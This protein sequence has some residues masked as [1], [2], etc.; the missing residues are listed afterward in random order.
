MIDVDAPDTWPSDVLAWAREASDGLSLPYA[1]EDSRLVLRDHEFRTLLSGHKLVAF[2]CTRLLDHEV[3]MVREE[4]L[5]PLT[6]DLIKTRIDRADAEG[7]LGPGD[8]ALLTSKNVFA[9]DN[10]TRA[11]EGRI[12]LLLGEANLDAAA[13]GVKPLLSTWGGEG[14]RGG[15][16]TRSVLR[17]GKPSVVVVRLDLGSDAD[18]A[19]IRSVSGAFVMKVLGADPCCEFQVRSPVPAEDILDI[20]QPGDAAYDRHEDLVRA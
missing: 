3:A 11:R 4:G 20:W 5:R 19:Y 13:Q 6:F 10:A 12:S 9:V 18:I 8:R 7:F 1:F 17:L 15:P 16:Q 2:H 14:M